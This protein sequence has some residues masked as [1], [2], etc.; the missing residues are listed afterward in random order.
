MDRSDACICLHKL[1]T[2]GVFFIFNYSC[3]S[4]ICFSYFLCLAF[5]SLCFS[6][7][8][9]SLGLL[10]IDIVMDNHSAFHLPL[11]MNYT[12]HSRSSAAI[13]WLRNTEINIHQPR[14]GF[15]VC[16]NTLFFFFNLFGCFE[17]AEAY[18]VLQIYF[19]FVFHVTPIILCFPY[20]FL[21]C[22]III[23]YRFILRSLLGCDFWSNFPMPAFA[24]LFITKN[25]LL[26]FSRRSKRIP[27]NI[28]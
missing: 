3:I 13:N 16:I 18:E 7:P 28:S 14:I 23:G 9:L 15:C 11:M 4:P 22:C 26:L 5:W 20:L 6:G 8:G 17:L 2:L 12:A 24:F 10:I 25:R 1:Y 21:M 19:C 27:E